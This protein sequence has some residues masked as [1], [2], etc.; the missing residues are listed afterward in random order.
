MIRPPDQKKSA[1][2]RQ[3]VAAQDETW[4]EKYRNLIFLRPTEK[5]RLIEAEI[6]K[7]SLELAMVNTSKEYDE[8]LQRIGRL[9]FQRSVAQTLRVEFELDLASNCCCSLALAYA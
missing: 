2:D 5:D 6:A 8:V 9:I 1:R 4:K 3:N 7:A